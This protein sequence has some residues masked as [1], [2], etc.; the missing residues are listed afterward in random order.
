MPDLGEAY[1]VLGMHIQPHRSQGWLGLNQTTYITNKLVHFNLSNCKSVST[2]F[3]AGLHLSKSQCLATLQ[4]HA[5]MTVPFQRAA[6]SLMWAMVC[7]RPDIV[8]SV[9]TVAQ[10]M[11][12]PGPIHWTALEHIIG[13]LQGTKHYCLEYTKSSQLFHLQGYTDAAFGDHVDSRKST[14]GFFF[15]LAGGAVSWTS[16]KKKS[17]FIYY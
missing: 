10:F 7:S 4:E 8:F 3:A 1:H 2:L 11:S 16:R 14:G 5:Y 12:N 13:Y 6:R 9:N 15:F 17:S